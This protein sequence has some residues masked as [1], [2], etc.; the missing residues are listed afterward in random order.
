MVFNIMKK[1]LYIFSL[2]LPV[3]MLL[4]LTIFPIT[5]YYLGTYIK[6]SALAYTSGDS[7]RGEGISLTYDI[8]KVKKDKLSKNIIDM[9]GKNNGTVRE[10]Y[11]YLNKNGDVYDVNK[12]TLEK[13]KRGI[14]L[15][16]SLYLSFE[17][18]EKNGL[19]DIVYL[20]IPLEQF[21]PSNKIEFTTSGLKDETPVVVT[22]RVYKGNG[23]LKD[24]VKK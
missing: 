13:P 11:I 19:E 16:C 23:V 14:Y 5:N 17:K 6:L 2:V 12:V 18:D 10:A 7:N 8:G 22:V 9:Q 4:G 20:N 21:Y 1:N 3:I 24:V 15:K